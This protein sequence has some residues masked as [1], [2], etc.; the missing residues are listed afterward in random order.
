VDRLFIES[1][2]IGKRERLALV[3]RELLLALPDRQA[4]DFGGFLVP[5]LISVGMEVE[6]KENPAV[7]DLLRGH[8]EAVELVALAGLQVADAVRGR[9]QVD[10][11]VT[12]SRLDGGADRQELVDVGGLV[13]KHT[14]N[15]AAMP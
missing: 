4:E 10:L 6:R 5:A 7:A 14:A 13:A 15:G 8:P 3:A 2:A 12:G 9:N 11:R 1:A